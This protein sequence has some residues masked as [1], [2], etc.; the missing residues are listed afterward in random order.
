MINNS[1]D[2]KNIQ[3]YILF[4][5]I[6]PRFQSHYSFIYFSLFFVLSIIVEI[7]QLDKL[8]VRISLLI[9]L[10]VCMFHLK[11]ILIFFVGGSGHLD[12]LTGKQRH[13]NLLVN[14]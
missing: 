2:D 6:F 14:L 8:H 1:N 4:K 13:K 12:I 5:G 3:I 9:F 10:G 11:D 7:S